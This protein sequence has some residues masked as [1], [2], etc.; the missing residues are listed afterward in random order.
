M[1]SQ[2]KRHIFSKTNTTTSILS[3]LSF[4]DNGDTLETMTEFLVHQN[5]YQK[6]KDVCCQVGLVMDLII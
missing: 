4:S 3:L 6:L 5:H 2:L 1:V